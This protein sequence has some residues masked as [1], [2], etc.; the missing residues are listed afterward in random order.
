MP[1]SILNKFEKAWLSPSIFHTNLPLVLINLSEMYIDLEP[2]V[3]C[4]QYL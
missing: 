4:I 3:R 1:E 2:A